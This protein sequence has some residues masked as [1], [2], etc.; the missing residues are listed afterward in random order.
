[1][2]FSVCSLEHKTLKS[3]VSHGFLTLSQSGLFFTL[4][5]LSSC[6]SP[7]GCSGQPF[8]DTL[9]S[10]VL[11]D[12]NW[13]PS[14]SFELMFHTAV[15]SPSYAVFDYCQSRPLDSNLC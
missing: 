13:Y 2:P 4:L 3:L 5:T 8:L 6:L 9:L 11:L 15:I 7:H 10:V 12:M 1:M 14:F